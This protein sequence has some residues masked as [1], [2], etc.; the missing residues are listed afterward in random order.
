[1]RMHGSLLEAQLSTGLA[2]SEQTSIGRPGRQSAT[3]SGV[4]ENGPL[5]ENT[6]L[7]DGR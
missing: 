2:L 7:G 3:L 4:I 5:E 6:R 1:M